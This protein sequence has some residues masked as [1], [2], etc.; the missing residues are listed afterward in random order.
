MKK[1]YDFYDPELKGVLGDF[2]LFFSLFARKI[3]IQVLIKFRIFCK[4]QFFSP[5]R[6]WLK[7]D[8]KNQKKLECQSLKHFSRVGPIT[9]TAKNTKKCKIHHH[10]QPSF[11]L[12]FLCSKRAKRVSTTTVPAKIGQN[13]AT[14]GDEFVFFQ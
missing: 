5:R 9:A 2:V 1:Q 12:F 8:A 14:S 4:N 10:L 6:Q 11:D 3:K 13:L 7:N